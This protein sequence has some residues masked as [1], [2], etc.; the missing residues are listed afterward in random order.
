MTVTHATT[1]YSSA[2]TA[3]ITGTSDTTSPW[4]W[5]QGH[6]NAWVNGVADTGKISILKK[7]SDATSFGSTAYTSWNLSTP[8]AGANAGILFL[9]RYAG[10]GTTSYGVCYQGWAAGAS[11]NGLGSHTVVGGTVQRCELAT[12]TKFFVSYEYDVALPWF[13]FSQLNRPGA[14]SVDTATGQLITRLD[15]TQTGSIVNSAPWATVA[16]SNVSALHGVP[17][18]VSVATAPFPG[19]SSGAIATTD[20]LGFNSWHNGLAGLPNVAKNFAS[21]GPIIGDDYYLGTPNL[22]MA[23][24]QMHNGS[25]HQATYD[26]IISRTIDGKTYLEAHQF[27]LLRTA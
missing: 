11:N 20:N 14:G 26:P 6:L 10:Q 2:P 12:P 24:I 17:T 18:S 9:P 1:T 8:E 23:F 16:F 13:W 5:V 15:R 25:S 19:I 27:Y 3:W 7:P 4:Y 21:P 22:D